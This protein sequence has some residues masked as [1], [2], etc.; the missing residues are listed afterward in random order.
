M[1]DDLARP[2]DC[3]AATRALCEREHQSNVR[4]TGGLGNTYWV[5]LDGAL[6]FVIVGAE[7]IDGEL[8]AHLSMS[9]KRP[10]RLPS[11]HELRWCKDYFLGDRKAVQVLPPRAQYVNIH[12]HVLNLYAPLE[13][14]PLPDFRMPVGDGTFAL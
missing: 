13:R 10:A 9:V 7:C 5:R 3:E 12:P 1:R 14:D 8:W 4:H 11:W 2:S 6:L